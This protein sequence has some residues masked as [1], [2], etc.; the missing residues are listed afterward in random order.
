MLWFWHIVRQIA[1]EPSGTN[2]FGYDP[3]FI[4][5]GFDTTLGHIDAE[6]KNSIS[7]RSKAIKQVYDFIKNHK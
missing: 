7:H 5:E 4:P 6:T 2:G 3:M 1:N